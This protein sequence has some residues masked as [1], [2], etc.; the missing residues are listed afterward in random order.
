MTLQD[1][2][3]G[4][5]EVVQLPSCQFQI[6]MADQA[7]PGPSRIPPDVKRPSR[8]LFNAMAPLLKLTDV[9]VFQVDHV[10][11]TAVVDRR[12]GVLRTDSRRRR[13][14]SIRMTCTV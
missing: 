5:L 3:D 6:R 13:S 9:H 11:R 2:A 14:G 1:Y 10:H 12:S 7:K 8:L 4:S